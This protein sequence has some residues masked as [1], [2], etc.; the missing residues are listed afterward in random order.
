MAPKIFDRARRQARE[1]A[2]VDAGTS[3]GS[4]LASLS[5][6]PSA[7]ANSLRS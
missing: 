3:A 2:V 1:K 4:N 7:D 5:K 6:P